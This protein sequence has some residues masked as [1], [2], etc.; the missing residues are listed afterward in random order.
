[1]LFCFNI[2]KCKLQ[3]FSLLKRDKT[4]LQWGKPQ[5]LFLG[6]LINLVFSSQVPVSLIAGI[7][8]I[9]LLSCT[10]P[11][12][13]LKQFYMPNID[14][15]ALHLSTDRATKSYKGISFQA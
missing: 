6:I 5:I 11:R 9:K 3:N 15:F 14:S 13:M 4:V 1:M 8:S 7:F 2:L 12:T 10:G